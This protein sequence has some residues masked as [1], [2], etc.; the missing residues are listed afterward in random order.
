MKLQAVIQQVQERPHGVGQFL[1]M[2]KAPVLGLVVFVFAGQAAQAVEQVV[3]EQG[4]GIVLATAGGVGAKPVLL[5]MEQQQLNVAR[6]SS[7]AAE[8]VLDVQQQS[9]QREQGTGLLLANFGLLACNG[10]VL[11]FL[12]WQARILRGWITLGKM[13]ADEYS[14]LHAR[15][16]RLCVEMMDARNAL[17]KAANDQ[18]IKTEAL[19]AWLDDKNR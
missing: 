6:V 9:A 2:L 14:Q 7:G 3:P 13:F 16:S 15:A 12:F 17:I 8:R 11:L 1:G 5:G 18:R 4:D 10:L 19:L